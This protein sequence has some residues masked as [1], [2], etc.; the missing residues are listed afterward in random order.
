VGAV[1]AEDEVQEGQVQDLPGGM[2]LG[3]GR[4]LQD[5]QIPS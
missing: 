1:L 3:L 5:L 2:I 4:S